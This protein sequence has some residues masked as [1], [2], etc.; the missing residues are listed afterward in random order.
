MDSC[1]NAYPSLSPILTGHVFASWSNF[2]NYY[3]CL[4]EMLLVCSVQ[5]LLVSQGATEGS[6]GP[7][8]WSSLLVLSV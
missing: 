3:L 8:S 4:R 5:L 7:L 1:I 2:C 6:L